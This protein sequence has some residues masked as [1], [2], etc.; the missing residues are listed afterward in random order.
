MVRTVKG[1]L[2]FAFIAGCAAAAAAAPGPTAPDTI[3]LT[4]ATQSVSEGDGVVRLNV[5][6]SGVPAGAAAVAYHTHELT[7]TAG[8]DYWGETGKL[9]WS[10]GDH[11]DKIIRVRLDNSTP[12]SGAKTFLVE[13]VDPTGADLGATSV[14]TVTILGT[15][16]PGTLTMQSPS[17]TVDENAGTAKLFVMRLGGKDGAAS[18]RYHTHE[19]T[20]TPGANY[21]GTTQELTWA[22]GDAD[23]KSITIAIKN[24]TSFAGTK[25]FLVE[26]D[27]PQGATLGAPATTTITIKGDARPSLLALTS[28]S[29]TVPETTGSVSLRALRTGGATG[30]A[31]VGYTTVAGTA[32]A[33][34]DFTAETGTLNWADGDTS[35]KTIN[36]PISAATPY[37]GTKSFSVQLLGPAGATLG[38]VTTTAV[39][40]TGE[41]V[42]GRLAFSA[43]AMTVGQ[44]AGVINIKVNRS[45]G[46]SGAASVVYA[47]GNGTAHAGTDF[48][49]ET[50]TLTWTVGDASAKTISVPISSTALF[51]GTK[52]FGLALASATGASLGSPS[53]AA[54]GIMG[55]AAATPV[56][57]NLTWTAPT[58]NDNGTDLTNLAGYNVYYGNSP[59][60]MTSMTTVSDPTAL[61]FKVS[62]LSHGTWY[63]AVS[64]YNSDGQTSGPS[65]TATATL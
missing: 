6:R 33:G 47:T 1:F 7:A 29:I 13:L 37:S 36:V 28:T 64:A 60:T 57:A 16:L 62:N 5:V 22:D 17:L 14:T 18:V 49:A 48:T 3:G 42:P 30:A 23:A 65:A 40:I 46:S 9:T 51:A 50:G 2:G 20:T 10:A 56:T 26:L 19:V 44:T 38:T 61:S 31:S 45:G 59:T 15:S 27:T 8:V 11:A 63:F 55:A 39:S 52:T 12:F 34:A 24:T 25:T 35:A 43:A 53:S 32:T 54:V 58:L 4:S 41:G 21:D